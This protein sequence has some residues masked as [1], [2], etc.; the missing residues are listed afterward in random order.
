MSTYFDRIDAGK[1]LGQLLLPRLDA[2]PVILAVPRGGVQVGAQVAKAL[3]APMLPL[4]VRKVGLPEAPDVVVGAIDADGALMTVPIDTG[5]LPGEVEGMG[6]DVAMRLLH[7]REVFGAPDPASAV[8]G[9]VAVIVDDAV[10]SGLT[11]KAGVAFLE[12]RGPQRIVVAV[13]CGVES[14]LR[15]IEAMGVEVIAPV[16]VEDPAEIPAQYQ[17]LPEVSS[18]EVAVLLAHGGPSRPRGVNLKPAAERSLRIIDETGG[19]HPAM[20]RLPQAAGTLACVVLCGEEFEPGQGAG[21]ALALRLAEAGVASLRL[22]LEDGAP[23]E[24]VMNVAISALAARPE[25]DPYRMGVVA[26]GS[27]AAPAIERRSVDQRIRALA[28]VGPPSGTEAPDR[29]LVV[30]ESRLDGAYADRIV[31]WLADRLQ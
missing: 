17:H 28:L 10:I 19:A 14:S 15:E 4:L 12:R 6:E 31:R 13:P 5:L 22:V 3:H 20:L 30:E 7:W 24:Q 21:D 1:K 2:P 9:H 8:R 29:S 26:A 27:A 16:R 23:P 18:E 25:M 11:T